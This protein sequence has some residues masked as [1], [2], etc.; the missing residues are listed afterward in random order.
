MLCHF[1]AIKCGSDEAQS[2]A[3][4]HIPDETRL[5]LSRIHLIVASDDI[6]GKWKGYACD[7]DFSIIDPLDPGA[8]P[9]ILESQLRILLYF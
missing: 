6:F 2:V 4:P 9:F 1:H 3:E 7:D 5:S 8:L